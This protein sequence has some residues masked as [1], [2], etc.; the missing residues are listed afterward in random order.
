MEG[1]TVSSLVKVPLSPLTTFTLKGSVCLEIILALRWR[2]MIGTVGESWEC[3][4]ILWVL[5]RKRLW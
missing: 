3:L 5:H 1:T 2:S 4:G